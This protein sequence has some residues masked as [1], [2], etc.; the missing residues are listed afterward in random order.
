[1]SWLSASYDACGSTMLRRNGDDRLPVLVW[2]T[3]AGL[4]SR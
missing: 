2:R 3:V 1:M 4:V